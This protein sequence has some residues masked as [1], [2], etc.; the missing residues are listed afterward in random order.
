MRSVRIEDAPTGG[1]HSE[2]DI[3]V[4]GHHI[5]LAIF[6]RAKEAAEDDSDCECEA[7]LV[8]SRDELLDLRARIDE[9][10]G[11]KKETPP[12]ETPAWSRRADWERCIRCDGRGYYDTVCDGRVRCLRCKGTGNSQP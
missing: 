11:D 3:E 4:D 7:S 6:T 2:I 8:L 10:L 5:S 9:V 12:K 1:D